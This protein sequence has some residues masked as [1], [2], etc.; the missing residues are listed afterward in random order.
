VRDCAFV[1]NELSGLFIEISQKITAEN[2]Y[3]ARNAIGS[4]VKS[5]A[6]LERRRNPTWRKH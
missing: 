2:N 1:E 5:P 6:I 3:A 4:S